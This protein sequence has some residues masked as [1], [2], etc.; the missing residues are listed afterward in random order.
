LV[1]WNVVAGSTMMFEHVLLGEIPLTS[2]NV[3]I[4]LTV[5]SM[6]ETAHLF[7]EI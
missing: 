7:T 6:G 4:P 5:D 1:N 3:N 2:G